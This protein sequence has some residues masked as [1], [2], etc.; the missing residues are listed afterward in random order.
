[1]ED[2]WIATEYGKVF[3][4]AAGPRDGKLVLGIHGYSQRSGWHTW[5]PMMGPLAEAGFR[6]VSV[7]MPGWGQSVPTQGQVSG[8]DAVQCVVQML[9]GLG[10]EQAVLMGK[11]WGGN[12]AVETAVTH[13]HLITHL[14]LTAPAIR[15]PDL[16]AQISQPVLL[17]W[18]EDDPVI[19]YQYAA[20]IAAAIPD[21]QLVTYPTGGH[22][23][24]PKN[25][26]DFGPKAIR[27]LGD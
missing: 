16:L 19:P 13:P 20:Q 6:M 21:C 11:S 4:K 5:E 1:M 18:A 7:D 15:K 27:F 2:I 9:A 8:D 25:A 24:A 23:A 17:A 14:I 10:A 3:A 26:A 12:V 22:S